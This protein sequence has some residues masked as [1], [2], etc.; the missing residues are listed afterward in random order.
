MEE[1]VSG[2][3]TRK[4]VSKLG[5]RYYTPAVKPKMNEEHKKNRLEWAHLHKNWSSEQWRQVIWSDESRFRV[6]GNDGTPLV[7]RKEGERYESCH[8]LRSVKFGGGS[9]MVWS[10][11]WAGGLG[12]L[13]FID[14]NMNQESYI[15]V[16]SQY[17]I[18]W[19]LDLYKNEDKM[20]TFQE[21]NATCHT[22]AYAKW[23]KRS[24]SMN[25]MEKWP[26]QSPD[27]NPIEHV[28]SELARKLRRRK[29]LIH[30]T[31]DLRR[32]LLLAWENIDV[33]FT[34]K[35]IESMPRRCQAVIDSKGDVTKY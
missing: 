27:L 18:P 3:T 31:E 35:L 19:V 32:E 10:C 20:F 9:L 1:N 28:W 2:S 22:G 26:A 11:F 16:L 8:T 21:D 7:L 30:N 5:F 12:P 14:G 23:W 13:V 29:N 17:Y 33:E 6:S 15:D 25:V 34:A 24:H 4:W